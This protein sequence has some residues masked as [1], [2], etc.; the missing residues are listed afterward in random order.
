MDQTRQVD[1][2]TTYSPL[3]LQKDAYCVICGVY[4][5]IHMHMYAPA[6]MTHFPSATYKF[7]FLAFYFN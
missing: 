4:V 5:Q 2:V 1:Q 3:Y 6:F 7:Y